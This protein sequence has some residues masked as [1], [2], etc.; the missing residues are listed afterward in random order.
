MSLV[1]SQILCFI[2]LSFLLE[3]GVSEEGM[4]WKCV[5]CIVGEG[6]WAILSLKEHSHSKWWEMRKGGYNCFHSRGEDYFQAMQNQDGV[7][8]C[9]LENSHPFRNNVLLLGKAFNGFLADWVK[10]KVLSTQV[11]NCNVILLDLLSK[12]LDFP[13]SLA[14]PCFPGSACCAGLF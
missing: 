2:S 5:G 4:D 11:P 13:S 8:R 3:G 12:L 7:F 1:L 9:I 6:I 10:P 14:G